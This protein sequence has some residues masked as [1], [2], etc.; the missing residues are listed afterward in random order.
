[1]I[2]YVKIDHPK[3]KYALSKK[4]TMDVGIK[5]YN[6]VD[7]YLWILDNGCLFLGSGYAWDGCSGPTI[8]DETNMRAGLVHDALYQLIREGVIPIELR[9][10]ADKLFY[11]LLREDGMSWIRAKLYYRAVRLFG[12]KHCK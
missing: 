10:K 7:K 4:Y 12:D 3:Y 8:D 6:H 1:M 11:Q 9:K 5:G 2:K